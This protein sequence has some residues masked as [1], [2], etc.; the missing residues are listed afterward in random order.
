LTSVTYEESKI[1]LDITEDK[2]KELQDFMNKVEED[3]F[4]NYKRYNIKAAEYRI[5][6]VGKVK[7]TLNIKLTFD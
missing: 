3:I 5:Y 1:E 7:S 4:K 2:E 6:R